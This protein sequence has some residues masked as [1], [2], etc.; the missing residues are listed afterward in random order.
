MGDMC[1]RHGLCVSDTV[2][3]SATRFMCQRH[4][5]ASKTFNKGI[6]Y[7]V[8]SNIITIYNTLWHAQL[9]YINRVFSLFQLKFFYKFLHFAFNY[10]IFSFLKGCC[11]FL[12]FYQNI[13]WPRT[14]FS[15]LSYRNIK[16]LFW[17]CCGVL[18]SVSKKIEIFRKKF[19]FS[20]VVKGN[21]SWCKKY[22]P[23]SVDV[24]L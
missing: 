8:W 16:V 22:P 21:F 5:L 15:K 4:G 19:F 24:M 11:G 2:Y 1:Q 20:I 13:L 7:A 17:V 9:Q 23:V 18:F 14:Y 10:N 6:K 3:V 12:S